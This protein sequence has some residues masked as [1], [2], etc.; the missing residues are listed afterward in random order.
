[1]LTTELEN[2]GYEIVAIVSYDW[3]D[4]EVEQIVGEYITLPKQMDVIFIFT[5]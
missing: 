4:D 2:T 5:N 3:A 1:M